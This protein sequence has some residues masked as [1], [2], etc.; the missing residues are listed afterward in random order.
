MSEFLKL[1]KKM[2]HCG[3]LQNT[4]A[5]CDC[6]FAGYSVGCTAFPGAWS[7]VQRSFST[8]QSSWDCDKLLNIVNCHR[9]ARLPIFSNCQ[10]KFDFSN[11]QVV[12]SDES[13]SRL[14]SHMRHPSFSAI[15]IILLARPSMTHD[16]CLKLPF[17]MIF[18]RALLAAAL[19]GYMYLAWN[20]DLKDLK[21]QKAQWNRKKAI[22]RDLWMSLASPFSSP[23][24][25]WNRNWKFNELTS[26]LLSLK[27][28]NSLLHVTINLTMHLRGDVN[29]YL[30]DFVR[31]GGE[32]YPP[33]P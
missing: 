4:M 23:F 15:A 5:G 18:L 25:D 21:Y 31:K 16:R 17:L 29:Y 8:Y 9:F 28:S 11:I 3:T 2:T 14:Y 24:P 32:G 22:L 12:E 13:L 10:W 1:L 27:L 19:I 33:N 20:P 6:V 7:T 30:A 26:E